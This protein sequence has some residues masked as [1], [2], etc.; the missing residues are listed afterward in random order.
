MCSSPFSTML[1]S[2]ATKTLRDLRRSLAWWS[3][4]LS[5]IVALMVSVYPTVRDMPSLNKLVEQYPDAIKGFVSFGGQVDYTSGPGYLGS[6]LFA[7]WVP[8]LLLIAAIGAGAR[9][10]AGEEELGTL[11][12]LLA[13]PISRRR[14]AGEKLAALVAEVALLGLV[15]FCALVVG[16]SVVAMHVSAAHLA[17][18][19]ASAVL[20]AV[21]FGAIALLVGAFTGRRASAIGISTAAAVAAYLVNSLAPLVHALETAR[22]AS[23][24]YHYAASDPLRHGL[25]LGH[26]G[27]LVAVALAAAIAAPLVFDRRDLAA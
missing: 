7:I 5:G 1:R 8:L 17:A 2:V 20:L 9:A 22:K 23:P 11:D 10:I 27:V 3:V 24:F 19:V 12:L 25:T 6:E 26:V 13:N 16:T 4:G 18:A 15:L 21:G 14:V